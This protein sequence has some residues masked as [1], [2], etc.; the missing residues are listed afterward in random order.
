MKI[1]VK[2]GRG[3]EARKVVVEYP[4][5]ETLR[6]NVKNFGEDLINGLFVARAKVKVQDIV[7]PM[8]KAGKTDK[9]IQDAVN[10]LK[11][12]ERRVTRKSA[13]EKALDLWNAM[14][15]EEKAEFKRQLT[16]KK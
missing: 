7:R 14:S 13:K 15:E 11:L 8:L 3:K 12:N 10:A 16:A 6:E 4:I 5:G 2:E 9:E 1:A